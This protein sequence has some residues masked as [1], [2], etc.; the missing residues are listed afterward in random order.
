MA[1]SKK[2]VNKQRCEKKRNSEKRETE[3]EI[4]MKKKYKKVQTATINIFSYTIL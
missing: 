3:K 4:K 1:N 2:F